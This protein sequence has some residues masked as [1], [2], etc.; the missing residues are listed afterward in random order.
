M[1][2]FYIFSKIIIG[3][4]NVNLLLSLVTNANFNY[5]IKNYYFPFLSKIKIKLYAFIFYFFE[6]KKE[7]FIISVWFDRIK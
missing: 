1:S 4:K 6:R 3:K 5:C 7:V 2:F